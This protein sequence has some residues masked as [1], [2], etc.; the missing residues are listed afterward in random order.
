MRPYSDGEFI[1]DQS[2]EKGTHLVPYFLSISSLQVATELPEQGGID[3]S[4][5]TYELQLEYYS[6]FPCRWNQ[7]SSSISS[8]SSIVKHCSKLHTQQGYPLLSLSSSLSLSPSMYPSVPFQRYRGSQCNLPLQLYLFHV[9]QSLRSL[10]LYAI[11]AI[12]RA[13][14]PPKGCII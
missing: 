11:R 4:V 1:P 13:V 6:N 12:T 3:P 8:I 14:K 5:S 9:I 7:A 10:R 2:A